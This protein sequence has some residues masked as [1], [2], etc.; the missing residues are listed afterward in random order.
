MKAKERRHLKQNE[1]ALTVNRL[2]AAAG[3]NQ[4]RLVALVVAVVIVL[5]SVGGYVWWR[6][7]AADAAGALLG[8]ALA[9]QQAEIV[10]PS[11]L[12]GATQAA[13]T[14]PTPE[15]RD[16]AALEAFREVERTYPGSEAA[17][18]AEY[19]VAT[20]LL[21]LGRLDEAEAAFREAAAG[22]PSY[23]TPLARLGVCEVLLR[24]G[25]YDEAIA[26]LTTLAAE[27]EGTLPI[28]GVLMQLGEANLKADRKADAKA[29]FQRVV[30]EF[31][32][33]PYVA[34]ARQQIE[35]IG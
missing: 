1:F 28:D 11:T 17:R 18:T 20:T 9:V 5:G 15:A 25:K 14:Y 34:Q 21:A 19:H 31:P 6:K 30:D 33:S 27:R 23:Y 22:D 12:P 26:E 16:E 13:G 8:D 32:T 7:R 10:P 3:E 24:E 2:M 35:V 4:Q 29:A